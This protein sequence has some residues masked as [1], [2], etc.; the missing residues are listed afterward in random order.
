MS[1]ARWT[2][3]VIVWI[4]LVV[5]VVDAVRHSVGARR[6]ASKAL[7]NDGTDQPV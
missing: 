5:L 6:R 2:G 3:F 7:G 1:P 4:A